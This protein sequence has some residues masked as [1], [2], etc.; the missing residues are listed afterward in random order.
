VHSR[1][2]AYVLAAVSLAMPAAGEAAARP[3]RTRLVGLGP[4]AVAVPAA[5]GTNQAHCGTPH[6][7]TVLIDIP[8]PQTGCA[9]VGRPAG[10]ESVRL[11][12]GRPVEPWAQVRAVEVRGTKAVRYG[13]ACGHGVCSA[14]LYFPRHDV[15][16]EADSSTDAAEVD[17]VLGRVRLLRGKVGLPVGDYHRKATYLRMLKEYGLRA[18]V[19]TADVTHRPPGEV[20]ATDPYP[21]TVL[22]RGSTVTVLVVAKP[23]R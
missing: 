19:L 14:V 11:Y 9:V 8:G 7:D 3:E 16:V 18:R 21:G 4:V 13:T 20:L 12:R 22:R 23:R 6:T 5:W 15:S 1:P 17:R 2:L 10:V